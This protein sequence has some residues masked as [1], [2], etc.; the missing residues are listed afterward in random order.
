MQKKRFIKRKIQV[1]PEVLDAIAES[2]VM[3][4]EEKNNFL[5]FVGYLTIKEQ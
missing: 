2:E 3:T 1:L 5:K 4:N